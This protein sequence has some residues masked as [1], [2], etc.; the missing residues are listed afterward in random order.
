VDFI[1][2][3]QFWMFSLRL[4]LPSSMLISFS[5]ELKQIINYLPSAKLATSSLMATSLS[6]AF[7]KIRKANSKLLVSLDLINSVA[8]LNPRVIYPCSL[9][10]CRLI[11][12][13]A[14]D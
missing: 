9:R 3:F 11:F 1:K 6:S 4:Y 14:S 10:I 2:F 12:E 13:F 7:F 5:S 8:I